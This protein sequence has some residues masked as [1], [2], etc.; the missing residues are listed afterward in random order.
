MVVHMRTVM[1]TPGAGIRVSLSFSVLWLKRDEK[2]SPG[3]RLSS[4]SLDQ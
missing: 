4:S 3:P 2:H 1:A